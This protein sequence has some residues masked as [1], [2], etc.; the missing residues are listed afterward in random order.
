MQFFWSFNLTYFHC[1]FHRLLFIIIYIF[2]ITFYYPK[3]FV[4]YSCFINMSRHIFDQCC[5]TKCSVKS[6]AI[7]LLKTC[8][9]PSSPWVEWSFCWFKFTA[10]FVFPRK[11]RCTDLSFVFFFLFP[12]SHC[13]LFCVPKVLL[14][15]W[16]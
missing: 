7:S 9:A 6:V 15:N 5:H 11:N 1:F 2:F 13:P 4:F 12:F 3:F 14:H 8:F 10:H 16:P